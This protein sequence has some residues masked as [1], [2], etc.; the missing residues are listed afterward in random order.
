MTVARM[1][2]YLIPEKRIYGIKASSITKYYVWADIIAFIVQAVGGTMLSGNPPVSTIKIGMNVYRAGI[3]LQEFFILTFLFVTT[4]FHREML[5]RDRS[6][7]VDRS[8]KWRALTW[9]IYGILILITVS[10]SR[11]DPRPL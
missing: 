11:H 4:K 3:G 1:I 8:I 7:L 6:G 10:D 5:S 2:H 9:T